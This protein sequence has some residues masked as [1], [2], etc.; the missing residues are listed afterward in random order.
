MKLMEK[1]YN[2]TPK[3]WR[4]VG[5]ALLAS[6]GLIG[7]GGLVAFDELKEVFDSH[8]LKII[9]GAVLIV[10]IAG[11]FLTNFFQEEIKQINE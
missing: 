4:K 8:E 5:D 9:I 6:A 1:Y 2:P 7:G 10:G 3:K 11:K